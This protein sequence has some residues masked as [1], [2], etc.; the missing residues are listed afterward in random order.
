MSHASGLQENSFIIPLEWDGDWPVWEQVETNFNYLNVERKPGSAYGYSNLGTMILGRVIE[1][2]TGDDYE[3][4]ID[5]NIFKPLEM[6]RSYFDK[7]PYH[8]MKNKSRSYHAPVPGKPLRPYGPDV[9]QGFTTTNGGWVRASGLGSS[10]YLFS[11]HFLELLTDDER[12]RLHFRHVARPPRSRRTFYELIGPPGIP[13]VGV[14]GYDAEGLRCKSCGRATG[15]YLHGT[16]PLFRDN[17]IRSFVCRDDL[18]NPLPDLF[19]VGGADEPILCVTR[20][21]WDQMRQSKSVTGILATRLGVVPAS[22]CD[23]D[24]RLPTGEK[25]THCS[26]WICPSGR[27]HWYLPAPELHTHPTMLWLEDALQNN[28]VQCTRE[29]L[30][31]DQI[32]QLIGQDAPPKTP[33]IFSFRCPHCWRLGRITVQSCMDEGRRKCSFGISLQSFQ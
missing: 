11:E 29:E 27:R 32:W 6:H 21:R 25:C 4:Y 26:D 24:P 5:K 16:E 28:R 9:D 10:V 23:R 18:P 7:T 1:V 19:V 3:T 30:T 20:A 2:V 15:S 8:L 33:R 22:E 31:F 12:T 17:D 13:Y 14:H